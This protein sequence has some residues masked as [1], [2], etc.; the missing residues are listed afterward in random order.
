[1]LNIEE[2]MS[3]SEIRHSTFDIPFAAPGSWLDLAWLARRRTG[4]G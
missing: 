3:K 2:G 1:M 4:V